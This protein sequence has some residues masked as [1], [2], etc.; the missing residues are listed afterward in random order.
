[1]PNTIFLRLEGP[2]QSWGER[3]RW[4]VRD[5]A[6]EPTK[7][8]VVGLLACALGLSA[9]EDLRT[10]SNQLRIGVR[11]DRPGM[12][13]RDY[14]TVVGGVMSAE[15]KVK[16]NATSREPETLVSERFYLTD[17]SFVVAI[18]AAP[19]VVSRIAEAVQNPVWP[20]YLG[21]R[22]CVPAQPVFEGVGDF[23]SLE[24][25]LSAAPLQ[26]RTGSTDKT[27]QLRAVLECLPGED[28]A[29]RRRDEINSR[30][31][32]TFYPRYS[33]DKLINVRVETKE[34]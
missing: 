15:D 12:V 27:V 6:P 11:C 30:M 23:D 21:R 31:R 34:V 19:D 28:G 25:A 33:R 3:S 32:R 20:F 14:H 2:M 4:S 8:G 24:I 17:A 9:D 1:M 16:I 13:L 7:S 22:S 10:L 26:D 29:V 18:Q 5:T